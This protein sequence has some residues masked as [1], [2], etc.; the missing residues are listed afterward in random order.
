MGARTRLEALPPPVAAATPQ[1]SPPCCFSC[2][3]QPPVLAAML[4]RDGKIRTLPPAEEV[5]ESG[6][7]EL[8]PLEPLE[9][10][11]LTGG[12]AAHGVPSVLSS[13]PCL[14]PS[15]ACVSPD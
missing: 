14:V 6:G 12:W 9:A 8:F 4:R 5:Q 7:A 3:P 11:A 1:P 10:P 13:A 15:V 2:I